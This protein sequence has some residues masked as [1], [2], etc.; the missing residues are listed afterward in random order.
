L[1]LDP[2]DPAR[3]EF[4]DCVARKVEVVLSDASRFLGERRPIQITPDQP[5][6]PLDALEVAPDDDED[7]DLGDDEDGDEDQDPD[8]GAVQEPEGNSPTPPLDLT[9]GAAILGKAARQHAVDRSE[10][11]YDLD[12]EAEQF[13]AWQ[14]GWLM[15]DAYFEGVMDA[16]SGRGERDNPHPADS[17]LHA[18]WLEGRASEI[19][20]IPGSPEQ[21]EE[22]HAA[23]APKPE[24]PPRRRGRPPGAKNRPKGGDD[25][26]SLPAT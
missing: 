13:E 5:T 10:N 17:A 7:L 2:D 19:S 26:P 3:S 15:Q 25:Q 14:T 9:H 18:A 8:P 22:A 20:K 1:I 4:F 24:T 16:R 6:L 11:P 23:P 21:R 12:D